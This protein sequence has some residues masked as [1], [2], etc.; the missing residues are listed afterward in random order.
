MTKER[1]TAT[2]WTLQPPGAKPQTKIAYKHTT[3][4][5]DRFWTTEWQSFVAGRTMAPVSLPM[6]PN[7]PTQANQRRRSTSRWKT[8]KKKYDAS[9]DEL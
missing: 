9:I 6:L 8:R 1:L 4:K 3:R 7:W 5:I 2:T